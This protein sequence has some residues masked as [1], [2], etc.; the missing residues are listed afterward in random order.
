MV[1]KGRAP[2][3]RACLCCAEAGAL[4]FSLRRANGD[5]A[6]DDTWSGLND[7]AAPTPVTPVEPVA[8]V[9]ALL[10]TCFNART[11]APGLRKYT[12]RCDSS[13]AR[14]QQSTL[15]PARRSLARK[16]ECRLQPTRRWPTAS[17]PARDWRSASCVLRCSLCACACTSS[18]AEPPAC[19]IQ[20]KTR[21]Q[22]V[23]RSAVSPAAPTKLRECVA[24]SDATT[25]WRLPHRGCRRT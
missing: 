3:R 5:A 4:P 22:G 24:V 2:H 21:L 7:D 13:Q 10:R 18:R 8:E 12:R 6:L 15:Q 14:P 1:V 20:N 25:E 17:A 16:R 23:Y 9:R 11:S 19:H